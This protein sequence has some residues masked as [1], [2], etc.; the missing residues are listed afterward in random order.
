MI[1]ER[2]NSGNSDPPVL[3]T[4]RYPD[5]CSMIKEEEECT[6]SHVWLETRC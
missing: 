1:P 3:V 2:L 5:Q 6:L 4:K